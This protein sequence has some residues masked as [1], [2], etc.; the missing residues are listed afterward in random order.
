MLWILLCPSMKIYCKPINVQIHHL[1]CILFLVILLKV[2]M[3][4]IA[5]HY[6]PNWKTTLPYILAY[7]KFTILKTLSNFYFQND[8]I[9]LT[10]SACESI[11]VTIYLNDKFLASAGQINLISSTKYLIFPNS[12]IK[13]MWQSEEWILFHRRMS[14]LFYLKWNN[15]RTISLVYKCN[16]TPHPQPQL[17]YFIT[18]VG[19][20]FTYVALVYD[21]CK[22][23]GQ[24]IYS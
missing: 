20:I 12:C 22:L 19:N 17:L 7:T 16:P 1:I 14:L 23:G 24:L 9:C 10:L 15:S 21:E 18:K 4:L 8:Y 6:M 2:Y 5:V 11:I 13:W 3:N